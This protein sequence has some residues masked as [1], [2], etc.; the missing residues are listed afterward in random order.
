MLSISEN[1]QLHKMWSHPAERSERSR[2]TDFRPDTVAGA[3]E[4][5][6][7]SRRARLR[8][9]MLR[10]PRKVNFS[11]SA[12]SFQVMKENWAPG[13]SF[14]LVHFTGSL[15]NDSGAVCNICVKEARFTSETSQ[16]ASLALAE[17]ETT[18]ENYCDLSVALKVQSLHTHYNGDEMHYWLA[19]VGEVGNGLNARETRCSPADEKSTSSGS[20][21]DNWSGS[22]QLE[23]TEEFPGF[24]EQDAM[25]WVFGMDK[26]TIRV[27]GGCC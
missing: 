10:L 18:L 2:R 11:M 13:L 7:L 14:E 27:H 23:Q 15:C 3:R 16:L 1:L 5:S 6:K 21:L 26:V 4:D 17:M 8:K 9:L 12:L 24:I 19:K 25:R 20:T 22:E